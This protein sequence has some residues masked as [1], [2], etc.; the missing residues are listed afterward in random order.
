M[1]ANDSFQSS[2]ST[3]FTNY[4]DLKQTLGRSFETQSY[5]LLKLDQFLCNLT[6]QPA[7]FTAETFGQWG[8]TLESLCSNVRRAWMRVVMNF[9]LYRRR[10]NP[11]CFVPDS[12]QF[13]IAQPTVQP[14][15]FSD[16]EIAN[17]LSQID[18][19]PVTARSPLRAAVTRIAVIL[20]YTTGIRRGELLRLTVADYD[21]SGQTLMIRS[22][23]FHKSRILPLPDDVAREVERFLKVH[24]SVRPQLPAN[25]PLLCSPYCGGRSYTATQLR[26]NIH[27]LLNSAEIKKPD[28]RLPRIHDFRFSF[29]VNAILRWYRNGFDVQA[30]L[31]FL[32]TYMGHV[33]ILSTYYY[34]KFVPQLARFAS[35]IFAANYGLL[36][37]EPERREYDEF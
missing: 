14:Y 10:S 31:P 30:K 7:D 17:V 24:K 26:K 35:D 19:I 29:A 22:S 36:I 37:Q 32:A 25:A 9:C 6:A 5:I 3:E 28:G 12:N 23:K 21:S 20:L 13:P 2:I 4:I 1:I 16:V 15:I 34:L 18:H 33:S 8:H 11:T 27:I